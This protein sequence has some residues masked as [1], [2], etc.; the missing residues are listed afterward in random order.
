MKKKLF[1]GLIFGGVVALGIAIF[2]FAQEIK[3]K[4]CLFHSSLHA[5]A[6]GMEYWYD[7]AN[8]GLETIT[9][10]PYSETG[11]SKCHVSSCDA[12]HK[13]DVNGKSRYSTE[14]AKKQDKCLSCHAREAHMIMKIDKELN[15]PDVHFAKGMSC[16]DCHTAREIHGDGVEYKSMKEQG[17]MDV[18]CEQCHGSLPKSASHKIHGNRLDCKACHVRHVVSCNSCHIET[19]LK[20][21]KRV[22]LP[23]SGWKFLMNYNG[24]V[25]SANM[26]S[27]V[28]PENKTFL[29]FA[30]Q[31]SHSVKKE[32]TKCEE[33]HATKTVE[34]IL[35][36]S[37][38]LSWLEGGKEQHIKGVIPVVSGVQY[39][40]VYQ[41]FKNGTWTPI[42]NP[43]TPKVQYVGYGSP[44][45]AEQ[46]KRLEKPQ[47]SERR[48]V[49]QRN[50]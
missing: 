46:L 36:G 5:T 41:N 26:Q 6:R 32:G 27:F 28:A 35:K 9:G 14:A 49:Q 25:T 44:L 50:N 38:D 10:I 11:C 23:V 24:R 48:N 20:E 7:K 18:K 17:A 37:I 21:K 30:P 1:A 16:M 2:G 43:A 47:K 45:T 29:I 42:S 3:N 4:D 39:D 33:C 34:Q 13:T 40:C 15:T 31:F 12:C 19:M 22:S 8:G